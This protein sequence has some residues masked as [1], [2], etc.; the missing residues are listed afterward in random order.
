ML[1]P[2]CFAVSDPLPALYIPTLMW[3]SD[4]QTQQQKGG[5]CHSVQEQTGPPLYVVLC[6][7][8]IKWAGMPEKL[9]SLLLLEQGKERHGLLTNIKWHLL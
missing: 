8:W 1:N 5:S 7:D 9:F 2:V 6:P 4:K 3:S